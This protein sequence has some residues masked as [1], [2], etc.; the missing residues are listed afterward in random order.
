MNNLAQE[1]G[2]SEIVSFDSEE[3]ILVDRD[4]FEVGHLNKQ[5]CHDGDGLLHRAFSLFIFNKQGELL[6]QKRSPQKRLWPLYWSNS[7]CSH[8]RYGEVMEE[9]IVRRLYQELGMRSDLVFLYK[10]IYQAPYK[11]VGS[12]HELCWVYVGV[13]EDSVQANPNEVADWQFLSPAEVDHEL[14][15]NESRYSPW[16]KL[17]W[18]TIQRDYKDQLI[19]QLRK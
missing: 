7:C 5:Q 13:S 14:A 9:A 19:Q 12:E 16:M 10:F 11:N 1:T 6:M 15:H 18:E 8:P 3:L 17:E 4:D 2:N